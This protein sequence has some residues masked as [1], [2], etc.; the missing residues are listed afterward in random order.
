[1]K[2]SYMKPA[3]LLFFLSL[4]GW[5]AAQDLI[6]HAIGQKSDFALVRQ[7]SGQAKWVGY[8]DS[9][10][11]GNI[12]EYFSFSLFDTTGSINLFMK[13]QQAIHVK[14]M[15]LSGNNLYFCG[16][17]FDTSSMSTTAVMGYFNVTEMPAPTVSYI[18]YDSLTTLKKLDYYMLY[19]TKHVVMVGTGK[20]G[21]DYIVDAY[22][23][24]NPLYP[25]NT[26]WGKAWTYITNDDA[27]FD[28]I[29]VVDTNVVVSARFSDSSVAYL[30]Y[31]RKNTMNDRPFFSGSCIWT[32]MLKTGPQGPVYLQTAKY[33]TLYAFYRNSYYLNIHQLKGKQ[34]LA[35]KRIAVANLFSITPVDL[36][37]VCADYTQ[38]NLGVLVGN[39]SANTDYRLYHIPVGQFSSG[40]TINGHLFDYLFSLGKS[41]TNK[42]TI[43]VGGNGEWGFHKVQNNATG[44]CISSL[45]A[46]LL[47][48]STTNA[49]L[50]SREHNKTQ[51]YSDPVI[52]PVIS[53][54][55]VMMNQ[56]H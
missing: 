35:S 7:M 23:Y 40:G 32:K 2:N 41:W 26:S 20:N 14:D 42:R 25:N 46:S 1:M 8:N 44:A 33:D 52:M 15:E 4:S 22:H 56:C 55:V 34:H 49:G 12:P 50:L 37:D 18:L 5:T 11:E 36:V 43:A 45:T 17:I 31:I 3:F 21:K 29:A 28:D 39:K 48:L 24:S 16:N 53:M 13:T 9:P 54:S 47:N 30:C 27:K 6:S 38:N 51:A 19:S 10:V